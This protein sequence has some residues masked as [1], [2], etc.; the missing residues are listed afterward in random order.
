MI[1]AEE[2]SIAQSLHNMCLGAGLIWTKKAAKA[3]AEQGKV[4]PPN[5]VMVTAC[6]E[7][8]RGRPGYTDVIVFPEV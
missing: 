4:L 8:S 2:A 3:A 1:E 5:R 6:T 7:P